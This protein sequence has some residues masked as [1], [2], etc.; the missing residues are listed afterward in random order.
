MVLS[1]T[2]TRRTKPRGSLIAALDVGSTKVCCLIA[3]VEDHDS[4]QVIGMGHQVSHGV[5]GG[6]IVDMEAAAAAIGNAVNSAEQMAGETIREVVANFSAAHAGSHKVSVEIAVDGHQVSELDLRRALSYAYQI[7]GSTDQEMI[8]IIPT[9]YALDG[10][11]GIEDPRGMYGQNLGVQLHVVTANSSAARNLAGCI[12]SS[13]L[14]LSSLCVSPYASGLSC[15]VDDEVQLGCTLIEMGGGTTEI[16]VFIGGN[17][18]HVDSLPVGGG[19]VTNDIARGLTTTVAHAERIKVLYGSA[20]SSSKDDRE[21]I[22][23]PQMGEDQ[24]SQAHQIPRSLLVGIV[25]PRL[26]ETFEMVR[27]RIEESGFASAAGRRVV[28]TG[29]ACQLSG[30]RDLAQLILDKQVRVGKPQRVAGLPEATGGTAFATAA[31]L[32]IHAL[33]DGRDA[34]GITT[35]TPSSARL[36][37]RVSGWIK[38]NL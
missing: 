36:F 17:L 34:P 35:Q 38:E 33:R 22:E 25:Q 10:N 29:G 6:T 1:G 16:A 4:V 7:E 32:L 26:E 2:K 18:V 31:G 5:R 8:H 28:L 20:L 15:L 12:G 14:Q 27:S 19:H 21:L 3:R 24:P 37:S 23:V 11:K 9:G 13:H 30:V